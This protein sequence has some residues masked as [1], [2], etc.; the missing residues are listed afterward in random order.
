MEFEIV[1]EQ[2]IPYKR[3]GVNNHNTYYQERDSIGHKYELVWTLNIQHE[4]VFDANAAFGEGEYIYLRKS[5]ED[6]A[7]PTLY[8]HKVEKNTGNIVYKNEIGFD[9]DSGNFV[10]DNGQAYICMN[11]YSA[12]PMLKCI[13]TDKG[14]VIWETEFRNQSSE[15]YSP[16]VTD[17]YILMSG[18]KSGGVYCFDRWTGQ[19]LWFN[20]LE[21]SSDWSPS[22][23]NDIV[24]TS[25]EGIIS[26]FE[27]ETGVK[28][29]ERDFLDHPSF[30]NS[31]PIIDTENN[32][33]IYYNG[34]EVFAISL[35]DQTINWTYSFDTFMATFGL[36]ENSLYA[37]N[38]NTLYR[39]DATSGSTISSIESPSAT[40]EMLIAGN[41][42]IVNGND[43]TFMYDRLTLAP[44]GSIPEMKHAMSLVDDMLFFSNSSEVKAYRLLDQCF[45]Y[46]DYSEFLCFGDSLFFNNVVFSES[47]TYTDT[48]TNNIGC[49]QIATLNLTFSTEVITP[50]T[51]IN[52]DTGNGNGSIAVFPSGGQEPYTYNWD[53]GATTQLNSD[54]SAGI[55]NLTITDDLQC[56]FYFSF[57]VPL[58]SSTQD[59]YTEVSLYPNLLRSGDVIFVNNLPIDL[60]NTVSL[61]NTSSELVKEIALIDGKI[62][63]PQDLTSGIYFIKFSSGDTA[64]G[65]VKRIVVY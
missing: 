61:Y 54:L 59:T 17:S 20:P 15:E 26:A 33:L 43:G 63:L 36:A 57:E 2:G 1:T 9:A 35:E 64:N 49:D 19:E 42:V 32:Q 11:E 13:D 40:N 14:E 45:E 65:V 46:T 39:I 22:Y 31:S 28:L 21:Q 23:Y 24:Y 29:W 60:N 34:E 10:L 44:K 30:G 5:I 58:A 38:F 16:V 41:L 12:E 4:D 47:G 48:I 37:K 55:Y 27:V 50:A 51:L 25:A 56:P 6:S 7:D 18:G 53:N 3:T 52:I 8:F 62:N